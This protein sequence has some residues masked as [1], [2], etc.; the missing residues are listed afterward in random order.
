MPLRLCT[1]IDD[2]SHTMRQ[3]TWGAV[4]PAATP[5]RHVSATCPQLMLAPPLGLPGPAL[6]VG[7]RLSTASDSYMPVFA[8]SDLNMLLELCQGLV[9]RM[10]E[11]A[12]RRM[13]TGLMMRPM[14]CITTLVPVGSFKNA[15]AVRRDVTDLI[16]K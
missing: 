16:A 11:E 1:G 2:N 12:A 8:N 3:F 13:T 10:P 5:L 4:Q 14:R 15:H 9:S 6:S 7:P